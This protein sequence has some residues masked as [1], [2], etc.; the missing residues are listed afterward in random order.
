M[1]ESNLMYASGTLKRWLGILEDMPALAQF[2]P[3]QLCST[4]YYPIA[5]LKMRLEE[6]SYEDFDAVELSLLR[7]CSVGIH[8]PNKLC[9]WMGLPSQRYVS[10]RL[11][12]LTA[13][14]L[15]SNGQLTSLG[16][17]SLQLGKKKQL[18]DTEQLFQADGILGLLLPKEYQRWIDQL[19]SREQTKKAYPHLMHSDGIAIDSIRSA[20]QGPEKIRNYKRYRKSVLNVNVEQVQ[21]VRFS[22]LRYL[23]VLLIKLQG[24]DVPL[25]F[26]PHRKAKKDNRTQSSAPLYLP[27]SLTLCLPALTQIAEVVPDAYLSSLTEM[28][29]LLHQETAALPLESVRACLEEKTA[30]TIPQCTW[31]DGRLM[32]T[33]DYQQETH[34]SPLDLELMA[35]A[36]SDTPM[37]VEVDVTLP[38]PK[39]NGVF[40]QHLTIWPAAGK[41]PSEAA[42]LARDWLKK[43]SRWLKE[44]KRMCSYLELQE[45]VQKDKGSE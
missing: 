31:Q 7:F 34:L 45:L 27:Q 42:V 37:P 6:Y 1:A 30:Y 38:N 8:A 14:G 15:L 43:S 12:I 26:L 41:I 17:D 32:V 23:K 13:E 28:Y 36:G 21:D 20:I 10:E 2:G 4:V 39:G 29:E 40:L 19:E 44:V 22:E 9:Q 3:L 35:A 5:L 11:S 33:L 25:V 18:Y 24:I 16:Q